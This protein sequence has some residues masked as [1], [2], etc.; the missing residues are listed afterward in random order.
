MCLRFLPR[1]P[2]IYTPFGAELAGQLGN[3]Q[4]HLGLGERSQAPWPGALVL[5]L[6]GP[7]APCAAPE[8]GSGVQS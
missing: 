6:G 2:K 8:L 4:N 5:Q 7:K 3:A 1:F